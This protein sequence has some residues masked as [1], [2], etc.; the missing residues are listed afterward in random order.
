[1]IHLNSNI[2][3]LYI[4]LYI[5]YANF[6]HTHTITL[7]PYRIV[8]TKYYMIGIHIPGEWTVCLMPLPLAPAPSIHNQACVCVCAFD[9]PM[10]ITQL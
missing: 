3:T 8:I 4:L 6:N 10:H 2:Y 5:T 1:M 7:I 9:R